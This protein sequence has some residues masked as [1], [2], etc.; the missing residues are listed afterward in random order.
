[1]HG[2]EL[3]ALFVARAL[4]DAVDE[5]ARRVDLVGIQLADLDELL[6]FGHADLAASGDHRVEVPRGFSKNEVAGFVALPRLHERDLGRDARF[7]HVFLAVENFRLLALGQ[8]GAEAG[9]RVK[10]RDARAARAQPL[11]QRA[12]R[13]EFEF[14]FARQHLALE[15]LVLADVGGHHLFHL[16]GGEQNPHAETIH[17]RVVADDGEA[18]HAAVVQCGDEILRYAAQPEPARGDRHVVVEQAG[19]RSLGVGVNF[20][21]VGRNLTTDYSN[22]HG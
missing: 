17:A 14:E 1:M 2:A 19:K 20:A 13:D 4:D 11:G 12:L 16:P 18:F 7:E 8:F 10:P 5:D 3:D 15:L 6:D 21:H 9:A 22:E